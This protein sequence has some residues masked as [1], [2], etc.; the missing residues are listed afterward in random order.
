MLGLRVELWFLRLKFVKGCLIA[1]L[2]VLFVN[3]WNSVL[4]NRFK[5]SNYPVIEGGWTSDDEQ[6]C[7]CCSGLVI[8]VHPYTEIISV[9]LKILSLSSGNDDIV[10]L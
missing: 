7:L 5:I 9:E 1:I 3:V 8:E 2:F 4:E 10:E 6:I